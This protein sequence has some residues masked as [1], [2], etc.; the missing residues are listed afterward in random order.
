MS[1][2]AHPCYMMWTRNGRITKSFYRYM[3]RAV[4]LLQK[5]WEIQTTLTSLESN[6][7]FLTRWIDRHATIFYPTFP[8][9]DTRHTFWIVFYFL[10]N[11]NLIYLQLFVF[12]LNLIHFPL[13]AFLKRVLYKSVLD[14]HSLMRMVFEIKVYF[15][16][17]RFFNLLKHNIAVSILLEK[18]KQNMC[19]KLQWRAWQRLTNQFSNILY[20]WTFMTT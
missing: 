2:Y 18:H 12:P 20:Q 1:I 19:W 16:K 13:M 6:T 3:P 14:L 15:S 8:A 4:S 10:D 9:Y 7:V 17:K 11:E 5:Q